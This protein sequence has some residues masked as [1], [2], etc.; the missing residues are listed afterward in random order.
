MP[1]T[2]SKLLSFLKERLGL[3][4]ERYSQHQARK[5]LHLRETLSLGDK[6]FLAVVEYRHQELLVGGTANS[7]TV[8]ATAAPLDQFA[9]EE[10][11][12]GKDSLQ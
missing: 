2:A 9:I 12:L 3:L 4:G 8:L 7:I 5:K 11:Y 6:R 1:E 10:G